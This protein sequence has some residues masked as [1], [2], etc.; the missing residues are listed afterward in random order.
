MEILNFLSLD[1]FTYRLNT[2]GGCV[3]G[4]EALEISLDIQ[5][6]YGRSCFK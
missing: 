6:F 1:I 3:K 4:L 5:E 2:E